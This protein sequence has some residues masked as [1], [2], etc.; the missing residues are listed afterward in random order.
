MY[1]FNCTADSAGMIVIRTV[2]SALFNIYC[3]VHSAIYW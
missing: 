2:G 1:Y 3:T